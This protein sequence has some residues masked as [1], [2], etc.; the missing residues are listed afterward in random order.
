MTFIFS[1]IF[2]GLN[3]KT[4]LLV[5]IC[6]VLFGCGGEKQLVSSSQEPDPVVIDVPIAYVKRPIPLDE[7][8]N[9]ITGDLRQP[10]EFLPGAA[11]YIK[12]RASANALE[13]N[14]TDRAFYT[15]EQIEQASE[16]NPLAGY[17]VKDV[18]VSYDSQRLVFAMR[19]PEIE[20][21]DEDEQPTWNIW[22]YDRSSDQ[23]RRII[24]SDIQAEE[25]QDTGPVYLPDGRIAFSSTRQAGNQAILL[26]EGKPQYQG[27]DEG[28]DEY[29]SVIHVMDSDG[30]DIQQI[31]FNQSHDLDPIVLSNGKILFSRWDQA[32]NNDSINLYQMNADGSGLEIL[33]GRH[34]HASDRSDDP[35]QFV[36]VRELQDGTILS[37]LRPFTSDTI[38]GDFVSIDYLNFID[39]TQPIASQTGLSGPAQTPVLFDNITIDGSLSRGGRFASVYPLWDGSSRVIFSWSQC[40]VYDPEQIIAEGEV[41]ERKI[42]PCDDSHEDNPDIEEAP[43]LFG[44][45]MYDGIENTQLPIGVPVEGEMYTEALAM[46]ERPYPNDAQI[47]EEYEQTLADENLAKVHIRS[48]Y[49]FAGVDASAQGIAVLSDPTQTPAL[50]R[51]VQFLRIVKSVSIPDEDVRD[52]NASAFGR[53]RNQLM[54]EI[55]GYVP[56]QPDGSALFEVPAN[57]PLAFSLVDIDGKR[58]G[59]RHQ[60]WLQFAPGEVKTCNGCHSQQST[61]PHGRL[62]AEAE[63]INF[64]A[65]TTGAPFPNTNPV[66]FAD[67]GETMAQTAGRINGVNY[68]TPDLEFVD[69]WTDPDLATPAESF[70][71][72]YANLS[73]PLPVTTACATNWTNLCRIQINYP[74]T[75]HPIFEVN[76]EILADDGMTV[77]ED[78]TCTSCHSPT[79]E[80]EMARVPLAQLDLSGSISTDNPDYLTSYR[81]LMFADSEQE[82]NEGAIVD[83]L[84]QVFDA[85]GD[86]V[87]ELDEDGELIL[88]GEGNPIPVFRTVTVANTMSTNGARNSAAF[89]DMFA[90]GGSHQAWLSKAELKLIA[91]WLDI[92]AQYYNNPFAA[93]AD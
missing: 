2:K 79:D 42:I 19:A 57:L 11:L 68:P 29:A 33:Y 92:G 1:P 76:R 3:R 85:N 5:A 9:L 40:R 13:I 36:K 54:R 31:S 59:A 34:S 27:L 22:E 55:I 61:L 45:W 21:A 8:G 20:D 53:S 70:Y 65:P 12:S 64:G 91:E 73:S 75:I 62:D 4:S 44:L 7:D 41:V 87:Y 35:L 84:V 6:T 72:A 80:A 93:P 90:A 17:D 32:G 15:P 89:F 50:Q 83:R 47:A 71:Y 37:A 81:E 58:V 46:E 63:S 18:D 28:L 25:G 14:I 82:L 86:P 43:L 56:V 69:I 16:E 38:G 48:V 67:M 39:N 10:F 23:L 60:N 78:R 66:L 74:D 49:D 52:F 26:D 24:S 51:P 77:L 30:T 88:D